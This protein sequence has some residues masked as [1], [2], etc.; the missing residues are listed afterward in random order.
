M[1]EVVLLFFQ[2]AR[3]CHYLALRI[4]VD[5]PYPTFSYHYIYPAN[6]ISEV[7]TECFSFQNTLTLIVTLLSLSS[8]TITSKLEVE[9]H[10]VILNLLTTF[11]EIPIYG[12]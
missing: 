8:L 2:Y 9:N 4:K 1:N 3:A 5:K 10:N 12:T 11:I 7:G 6:F